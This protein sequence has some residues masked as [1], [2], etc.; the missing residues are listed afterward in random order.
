MPVNH[1]PHHDGT[2]AVHRDEDGELTGH[3]LR[4]G[5]LPEP[6]WVRGIAHWST[7]PGAAGFRRREGA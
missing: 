1:P 7:C 3:V 5:R 6:G 2:V 4:A